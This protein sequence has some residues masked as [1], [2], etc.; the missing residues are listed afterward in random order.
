LEDKETEWA[1][2]AFGMTGLETALAVVIA[3]LTEHGIDDPATLWP[4]LADRMSARP[5]T[6]GRLSH[7]GQPLAAGAPANLVLVDATASWTVDPAQSA[8]RGRNTPFA[9]RTL[10]ARVTATFLRGRPTVLDGKPA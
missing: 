2:A 7:Q 10:P 3:A 6:I 1:A 4:L 9:G 5:A 8:S